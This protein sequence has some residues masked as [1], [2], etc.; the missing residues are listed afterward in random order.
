MTANP[1][2]ARDNLTRRERQSQK[3]LRQRSNIVIKPANKGSAT[4]GG[5]HGGGGG[6]GE[7]GC[8]GVLNTAT[9]QKN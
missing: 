8:G 5:G 7:G 9:P 3:R 4:V 2:R 6:G 1:T